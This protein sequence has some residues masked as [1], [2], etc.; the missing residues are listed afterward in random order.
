[1]RKDVLKSKHFAGKK[2]SLHKLNPIGMAGKLE[3]K[4]EIAV[5]D[6]IQD[7]SQKDRELLDAARQM[8]G[9][10]YAPYSKFHVGAAILLSD[11]TVVKG[12]NQENAAYPSGLCAERS[13]IYW[14]GANYPNLQVETVAVAAR[15]SHAQD[16][17]PVT[18]CGSCR[19][20]LA[21]YEHKQ[22]HNIRMILEAE[23]GKIYIVPSI[24]SLL[25]LQF[26]KASLER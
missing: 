18:P 15:H 12:S 23:G 6:S 4:I 11:G 24:G 7:L 13:A 26:S 9:Q 1:M 5:Y 19:Q 17:L 2:F 21:E 10:A 8:C 3:V 20:A 16:F 25:P 22:P 14:A